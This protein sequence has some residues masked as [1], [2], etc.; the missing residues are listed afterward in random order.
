MKELL[1]WIRPLAVCLLLSL[2][3]FSQDRAPDQPFQTVHLTTSDEPGAEK[4]LV[5]T[6]RD[7][8]EVIT[9]SGCPKCIYHLYKAYGEPSGVVTFLWIA[10][11]PDR[12]TYEK[13]HEAPAYNA[14]WARH[15]EL[16]SV[17]QGEIYNRYVEVKTTK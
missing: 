13:I 17:R 4:G 10:N 16:A 8:N 12:A 3:A 14:A 5:E 15:P 7:L 2:P 11:W 6:I 1:L 9:R